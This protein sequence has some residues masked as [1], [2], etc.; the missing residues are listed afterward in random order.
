MRWVRS[1]LGAVLWAFAATGML[2]LLE[3]VTQWLRFGPP[4]TSPDPTLLNTLLPAVALYGWVG[5]LAAALAYAPATL[6]GRFAVRPRLRAF[7]LAVGAAMALI[8]TVHV[9]YLIQDTAFDLWWTS[10][11]GPLLLAKALVGLLLWGPCAWLTERLAVAVGPRPGQWVFVPVVLAVVTTAQWPSWREMRAAAHTSTLTRFREEPPPAGRPNLLILS[12]DALRADH[13]GCLAPGAPPTPHLDA[14][15]AEGRAYAEAW[16]VASW[17][18]PNMATIL[19]GQP[20]RALGVNRGRGLPEAA[21]TLAEVAWRHGWST[22]AVITNPFLGRDFGFQRGFEHFDHSIVLESLSPADRSVLARE[23]TRYWISN[24]APDDAGA[25]VPKALAWL[26]D[27]PRDRPFFLWVHLL[28]PHLPYRWHRFPEDA[29]DAGPPRHPLIDGNQ[30]ESLREVRR[31]LPDVDAELTAAMRDLYRREVRYADRWAGRLLEGLRA[32]ELLDETVVVV[33]ADHGEEFFEH[34]GF[35]H[36]H[37]LMPE[38][39]RV[40]L[41]VR[42]PGAR[43]AGEVVRTPVT[44]L[45]LVPTLCRDLG[46]TPPEGLPGAAALWPAPTGE[47][48]PPTTP[49]VLENMLYGPPQQGWWA[50][51]WLRLEDPEAGTVDWYDLARDPGCLAPL[52]APPP[53]AEA[54]REAARARLNAWDAAAEQIGAN[55]PVD[56]DA[57]SEHT[58]RQLESLGY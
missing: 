41:I 16:G 42:L 54:L 38:V 4:A 45:D 15:A 13:V 52:D 37:T 30:F 31:M 29:P 9:G 23:L 36:G 26:D 28:E 11:L 32:R 17:T 47:A 56:P 25:V 39:T 8:L 10:R 21:P 18:L 20:P 50:W 22:A 12:I 35:E 1:W 7:S 27:E 19:T 14:L 2:G 6:A 48:A 53:E 58:R 51:P 3:G 43:G 34:G 57:V 46:W 44:V 55:R 49:V 24:T 33:L 40:P 5:L